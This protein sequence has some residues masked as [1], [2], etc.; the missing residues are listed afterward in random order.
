MTAFLREVCSASVYFCRR[1]GFMFVW[2]RKQAG[3]RKSRPGE[4]MLLC[5]DNKRR[6]S[7]C[8]WQ[9]ENRNERHR[10]GEGTGYVEAS[11][12]V[13]GCESPGAASD[14]SA[15]PSSSSW[16]SLF[17]CRVSWWH[18]SNAWPTV[19]TILIAWDCE[20]TEK[21]CV[22]VC[23]LGFW[24]Q[25]WRKAAAGAQQ[26]RMQK[27]RDTVGKKTRCQR[28]CAGRNENRQWVFAQFC[29]CD[30]EK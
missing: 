3:E 6:V 13:G 5:E 23:G 16:S 11:V 8:V 12:W 29:I 7:L 27:W 9:K 4:F 2:Q 25:G 24:E 1:S 28:S 15:F 10:S 30:N 21:G 26:G 20:Y 18:T 19:R 17:C 14:S 22:C